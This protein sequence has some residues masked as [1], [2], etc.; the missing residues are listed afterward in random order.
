MHIAQ[1]VVRLAQGN[2]GG[3]EDPS[4]HDA[5][6]AHAAFPGP[7]Q[8]RDDEANVWAGDENL[9]D[10]NLVVHY[11]VN[12]PVAALLLCQPQNAD[13]VVVGGE[14]RVRGLLEG[15]DVLATAAAMRAFGAEVIITPT[16]V[17]Y[18]H[19]ENYV[20]KAKAIAEKRMQRHPTLAVELGS[21]HLGAAETAAA[22]RRF[23]AE[24]GLEQNGMI[25]GV[26]AALLPAAGITSSGLY[27]TPVNFL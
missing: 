2:A 19:P 25:D 13:W 1:P 18:D 20:M 4:L 8:R 17:P 5:Y 23:Q 12:D 10:A 7:A 16:A 21:T 3:L 27:S 9:V 15:E 22:V 26:T 11:R 24:Q 6:P 14:T